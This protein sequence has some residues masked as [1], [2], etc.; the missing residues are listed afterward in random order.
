MLQ[1]AGESIEWGDDLA[2]QKL[3]KIQIKN[4]D[5]FYF[6]VDWPSAIKPFYVKPNP[7]QPRVCESFDLMFKSLEISSGSTRIKNKEELMDR[8]KQQGLKVEAFDSHLRIFDY[9][10]PPHAG[11][12]VGLERLMMSL[13][14]VDN[15][16]DATLYP[17]DID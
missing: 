9:G 10:I 12:G 13:C 5:S 6:I 1:N 8:M 7:K 17:R 4:M 14:N 11:F 16:R 3:Q 2:F 15:I